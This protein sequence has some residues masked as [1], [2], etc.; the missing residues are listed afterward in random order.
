M[1]R[2]RTS[3]LNIAG[4]KI[5]SIVCRDLR[6]INLGDLVSGRR[7]RVLFVYG[8]PRWE[9]ERLAVPHADLSP[10][11]V[12]RRQQPRTSKAMQYGG[13]L[14]AKI[15]GIANTGIHA[16]AAVWDVLVRGVAGEKYPVEAVALGDQQVRRPG[17]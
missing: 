7:R 14:P 17:A 4:L 9:G 6:L 2:A 10:L 13:K 12:I 8:G 5:K 16:I 1:S 3:R 15:T 11:G